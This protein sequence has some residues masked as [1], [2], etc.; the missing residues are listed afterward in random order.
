MFQMREACRDA[1]AWES[2]EDD[3]DD[4]IT[5]VLAVMAC[6]EVDLGK[7]GSLRQALWR[8]LLVRV[9]CGLEQRR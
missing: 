5:L 9:A 6:W 1:S 3:A 4:A 2:G 8:R 7:E